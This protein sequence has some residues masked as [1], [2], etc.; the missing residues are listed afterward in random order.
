M[1]RLAA[2]LIIVLLST[3]DGAAW[4]SP[5]HEAIGDAAQDQLTQ[6]RAALAGILQDTDVLAPGALAPGA[7]AGVATGPMIC[8]PASGITRWP[9]AGGL[10]TS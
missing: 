4:S 8:G 9:L 5:A 6:A 2:A 10:R 3:S 7:L 1:I